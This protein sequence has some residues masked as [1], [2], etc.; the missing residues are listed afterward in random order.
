MLDLTLRQ[1]A[2]IAR[3]NLARPFSEYGSTARSE[4]EANSPRARGLNS[5]ASQQIIKRVEELAKKKGWK[6]SHVALAWINNRVTSPIVGLSSIAR[7]EEAVD[8][9][10]KTLTPE[11]EKYLEEPYE[12]LNIDGHN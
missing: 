6:M 5:E 7:L 1:W 8:L 3:G 4:G 11:E 12:P 9:Q 10:G 2:P